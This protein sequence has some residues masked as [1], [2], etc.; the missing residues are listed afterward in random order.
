MPFFIPFFIPYV[1]RSSVRV[2]FDEPKTCEHGIA[3][4]RE[5]GLCAASQKIIEESRLAELK[6]VEA[7]NVYIKSVEVDARMNGKI[8]LPGTPDAEALFEARHG[9]RG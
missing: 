6:E 5:C 3:L 1:S 4:T 7:R 8:P 9:Y 2:S